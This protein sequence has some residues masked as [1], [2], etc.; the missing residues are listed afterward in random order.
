MGEGGG[1]GEIEAMNSKEAR[2]Q[3]SGEKEHNPGLKED[4]RLFRF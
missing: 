3:T 4:Y 1:G 2:W